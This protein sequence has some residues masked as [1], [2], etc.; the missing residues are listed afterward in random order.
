MDGLEDSKKPVTLTRA[1]GSVVEV[2]DLRAR[3]AFIRAGQGIVDSQ[4]KLNGLYDQ[5]AGP[6]L[7]VA[8]FECVIQMPKLADLEPRKSQLQVVDALPV[9]EQ[10][11]QLPEPDKPA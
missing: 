10:A 9:S 8:V 1:D 5:P 7:D 11:K 6:R 3:A 2:R 4:A